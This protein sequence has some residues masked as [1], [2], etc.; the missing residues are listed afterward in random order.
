MKE[1]MENGPV[2]GK[3]PSSCPPVPEACVCLRLDTAQQHKWSVEHR[4]ANPLGLGVRGT[5]SPP[6]GRHPVG[7]T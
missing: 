5:R 3:C 2:Q 7:G 4:A 1:L 6:R